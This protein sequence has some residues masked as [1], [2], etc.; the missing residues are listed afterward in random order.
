MSSKWEAIE[1]V[2]RKK[3]MSQAI[4][5]DDPEYGL[6]AGARLADAETIAL[7]E[8]IE[9]NRSLFNSGMEKQV[10]FLK[11]YLQHKR[12]AFFASIGSSEITHLGFILGWKETR[13]SGKTTRKT[14]NKLRSSAKKIVQKTRS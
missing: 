4:A 6:Y 12:K 10:T 14:I 3:S 7:L 1:S 5:R 11:S 8:T 9:E 2:R 13:V